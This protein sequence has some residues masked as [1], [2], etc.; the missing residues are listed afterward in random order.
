M[1]RMVSLSPE[2]SQLFAAITIPVFESPILS[3][4]ENVRQVLLP[5]RHLIHERKSIMRKKWGLFPSQFHILTE[6]IMGA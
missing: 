3:N 5:N 2:N 4:G 1:L 6:G